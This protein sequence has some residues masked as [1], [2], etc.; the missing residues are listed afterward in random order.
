[1]TDADPQQETIDFLA[2]SLGASRR[3]RTHISVVLLGA[4][5]VFKLKR[6]VR[7]P[8]L[9]F[10]T[11]AQRL[12]MCEREIALN[13][14]YSAGLYLGVR[15]V[16]RE[17]DGAL[18]LDGAGEFVDAAVQMR[19][20][21][22]DAL[23]EDMARAGRLDRAMIE[24]LARKVAQAHD[25][26]PPDPRHGGAQ[27]MGRI[28]DSM[29]ESFQQTPAADMAEIDTHLAALRTT[30]DAHGPEIDRRRARGRVRPCHGDLNLRNIC[31]FAGEP[32]PFD[33]IEF[34]DDI[35]TI[36][37]LYDIAFLLMDL[38]RMGLPG[39][40][41]VAFNRYLDAR[42]D[43]EDEGLPLLPFFISLRA[44]IRAHVEASQGHGETARV[45][46]DLSRALLRESAGAI[47]AIG[48]FSGSGKSSVAASLAPTLAPAPGAR[49]LNSDRI[50][51]GLFGVAPAERLPATAYESAVSA[52]VYEDMFA[53]A[54]RAA[55]AGWPVVVD[56]VFDRPQDRAA[57]EQAAQTAGVPFFGFWLDADLAQR[58]ARVE[59]RVGDVSDATA[60]LLEAQAKKE[61]GEIAWRRIDAAGDVCAAAAALSASLPASLRGA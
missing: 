26:A 39:L 9:D 36:D 43:D 38:W 54:A 55:A 40:A 49:I 21:A 52:K 59:R 8:Y 14:R 35:S 56:A 44:T 25:A 37:V 34:S 12:Q 17:A 51:K 58:S 53:A 19:R 23:F 45:F 42:R 33:C 31:V 1:M 48:G 22:D 7:L 10:S 57:I 5:R 3:I 28:I 13:R 20:F 24:T 15:R 2:R 16:T 27:A 61:T 6:A 18:A 30:L 46:F 29:A 32:T 11:P 50:R 4:E 47:V 41:N 60:E